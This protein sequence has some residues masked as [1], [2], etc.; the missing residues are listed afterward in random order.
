MSKN[1]GQFH[2]CWALNRVQGP[3]DLQGLIP[4]AHS[5]WNSDGKKIRQMQLEPAVYPALVNTV[6]SGKV[7]KA[8]PAATHGHWEPSESKSRCNSPKEAY[9]IHL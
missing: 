7:T 5:L 8:R 9:Y 2:Q 4:N 1:Q 3:Y 6:Q